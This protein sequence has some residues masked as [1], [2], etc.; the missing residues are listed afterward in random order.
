MLKNLDEH[1][2]RKTSDQD[3]YIIHD[4]QI[5]L[6][7][8]LLDRMRS[9]ELWILDS[10][11]DNELLREIAMEMT[12]EQP[13]DVILSQ[14]QFLLAYIGAD[15]SMVLAAI[16]WTQDA[17]VKIWIDYQNIINN[18][19]PIDTNEMVYL[20]VNAMRIKMLYQFDLACMVCHPDRV[21]MV[22]SYF[23]SEMV[24]DSHRYTDDEF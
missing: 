2:D 11:D 22:K 14:D 3:S 13:Q 10:D 15:D 6:L 5:E 16:G 23:L 4:E 1:Q 8:A 24:N 18:G 9:R 20:H 19:I 12:M 7:D 21:A 17:L